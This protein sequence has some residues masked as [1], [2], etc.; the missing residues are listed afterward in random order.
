LSSE[1]LE[2]VFEDHYGRIWIG[3]ENQ[4]IDMYDPLYNELL[5]FKHQPGIKGAISSNFITSIAEDYRRNI[6]VGTVNGG[7]NQI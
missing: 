5:Q 3:T 4:G 1:F 6:Y 2:S 7:V